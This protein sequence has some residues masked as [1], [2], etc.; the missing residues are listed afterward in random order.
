MAKTILIVDDEPDIVTVLK[1][2][3]ISAGYDVVTAADGREALEKVRHAAPD[4]IILDLMLPKVNG[5]EVC[6][7]LKQD[8]RYRKIPIILFTAL[9]QEKDKQLAAQCG[10]DAY[11]CKPFKGQELLE[12]IRALLPEAPSSSS[13]V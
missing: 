7:M 10:A 5:F 6:T 4:V 1:G 12:R 13:A 8:G 11:V 9:T 2:R 3:L